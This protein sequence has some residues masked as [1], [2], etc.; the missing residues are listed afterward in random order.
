MRNRKKE[1]GKVVAGT[2]G[3]IGSLIL[4][5]LLAQLLAELLMKLLVS[6]FSFPGIQRDIPVWPLIWLGNGAAGFLYLAFLLGFLKLL[7][8]KGLKCRLTDLGIPRFSIRKKWL[9]IGVLLPAGVSAVNLL[10]PG[11]FFRSDMGAEE[12]AASLSAGVFYTGIAAGFAEEMVFRG[13][14]LHLLDRT[15]G[16]KTAILAPSLLFGAVHMIGTGYDAVSSLQV[17]AAGTCVGIMFS[18]I[19]LER[20]SVWNSG[21]VHALWNI[22]MLGGI[23]FIGEKADV[24]SL[25]SYVPDI[26]WFPI[27]GGA[28]GI[29][30][31]VTAIAGYLAVGRLALP[32]GRRNHC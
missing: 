17:C 9:L 21:A 23:L 32:A 2:V 12:L 18:L 31:S 16:R 19:A 25:I 3:A 11:G 13:V 20:D 30:A 7:A 28:F 15:A 22:F 26:R 24:Y 14:I 5:Q 29:E 1:V 8:E 27:T 10:L 6:A 4:S